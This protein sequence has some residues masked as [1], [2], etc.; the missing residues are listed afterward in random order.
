MTRDDESMGA[1]AAL[2]DCERVGPLCMEH[3][4]GICID[5]AT[6]AGGDTGKGKGKGHTWAAF[7]R[8]GA[9]RSGLLFAAGYQ[10]EGK[11]DFR[12]RIQDERRSSFGQRA[13]HGCTR[14]IRKGIEDVSLNISPPN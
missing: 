5:S 12:R 7:M 9:L 1:A 11:D 3:G 4:G 14:W 8:A 10:A 2:Y 6:R 13:C